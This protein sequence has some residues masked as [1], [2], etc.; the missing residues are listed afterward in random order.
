MQSL[1]LIN[2]WSNCRFEGVENVGRLFSMVEHCVFFA[3][4]LLVNRVQLEKCMILE[5][6]YQTSGCHVL[7]RDEN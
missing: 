2:Y 4:S 6:N 3:A 7:N 1:R 5:V